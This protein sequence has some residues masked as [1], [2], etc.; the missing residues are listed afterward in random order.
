V[1]G[2]PLV[3]ADAV[4]GGAGEGVIT[5][6]GWFDWM[7]RVPGPADKVYSAPCT[8]EIYIPHSAV[9]YLPGWYSRLFSTA[10][11][12]D[13]Q[14]TPYAAASVTGWFFQE[15]GRQP[16]Q[17]YPLTK[18]CWGSGTRELNTR[19]NPFENEGGPAS[20]KNE[21]LTGWQIDCNLRAMREIGEWKGY[22]PGYWRRPAF[23][24]DKTA[25][26]V[27]H[28]ESVWWGGLATECP[29]ERAR[30]IW[31]RLGEL[32]EDDMPFTP[33]Q[34]EAIVKKAVDTNADV[35]MNHIIAK[36]ETDHRA[37]MRSP[38]FRAII[39]GAIAA[40]ATAGATAAQIVDEIARRL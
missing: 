40:G 2:R 6:D 37:V 1:R 5:P 26:C 11:L 27:E 32:Q 23:P 12:P 31:A 16:I 21:P 29:S 19:G 9:G 38:E 14:Y 39:A 15:Q 33:E 36:T 22:P 18:S 4:R 3:R 35:R 17:H 7:E 20:N 24:G 13:G 25:T 34:L 28:R 30:A 10:R 8:S